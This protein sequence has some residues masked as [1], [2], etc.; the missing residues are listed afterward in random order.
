MATLLFDIS[1]FLQTDGNMNQAGRQ[2]ASLVNGLELP[3]HERTNLTYQQKRLELCILA[4]FLDMCQT[5][6][7]V[8]DRTTAPS[9]IRLQ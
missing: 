1:S 7:L 2:L 5:F 8:V 3:S 9:V 6:G 4:K